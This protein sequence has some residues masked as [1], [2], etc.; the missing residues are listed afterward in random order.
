[1][2]LD[3]YGVTLITISNRGTVNGRPVDFISP[4]LNPSGGGTSVLKSGYEVDLQE[5]AGAVA[6][7]GTFCN[8]PAGNVSSSRIQ[9]AYRRANA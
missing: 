2:L 3:H 5:A 4:D 7:T 6:L 8:A 9:I 1:M